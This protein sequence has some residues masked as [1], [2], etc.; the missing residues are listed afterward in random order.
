MDEKLYIYFTK[1]CRKLTA[2]IEG[3]TSPKKRLVACNIS[4]TASTKEVPKPFLRNAL[5]ALRGCL[6]RQE[7]E[8]SASS[9]LSSSTAS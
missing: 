6:P 9:N 2:Y 7:N 5:V 4:Q 8:R 3:Y 1:F